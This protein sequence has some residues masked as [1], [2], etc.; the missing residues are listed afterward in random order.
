MNED[1]RK[2]S[3]VTKSLYTH[4]VIPFNYEDGMAMW[5]VWQMMAG[6]LDM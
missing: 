2:L 6:S 4:G 3:G 1:V 5:D